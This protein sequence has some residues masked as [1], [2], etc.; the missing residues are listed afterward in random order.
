MSVK[1]IVPCMDIKDGKV[2]KGVNFGGIRD[3]A[4]PVELAKYYNESGADAVIF[5]DIAATVQGRNIFNQLLRSVA[6]VVTIPLIVGGG[7]ASLEDFDR[8]VEYGAAKVSINSGAIN[9]PDLISQVSAKYGSERVILS[10]DVKKVNGEYRVFKAAGQ[11]DTGLD[12]IKWAKR[13][14]EKGAGELV[15]NS[16]DTDGVKGGYDM[17]LLKAVSEAV[18]VPIV[19]SGGAGKMEDF[20]E[21]FKAG[22]T[23]TG[24]AASVFHFKE[25]NIGELKKY[26]AANGINVN[27]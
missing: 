23:E 5:Y 20:L 24:L 17:P 6:E 7:I 8:A 25:I 12:A 14:V 3:V 27:I 26:L 16:I 22:Y 15:V 10:M 9:N 18:D 13:N 1:K 19:A 4:D 21:V 11:V 2:V